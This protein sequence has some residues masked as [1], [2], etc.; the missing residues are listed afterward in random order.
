VRTRS[1]LHAVVLQPAMRTPLPS[2]RSRWMA[3]PP[4][5]RSCTSSARRDV[6]SR[7]RSE[8]GDAVVAFFE[9][10]LFSATPRRVRLE[11]AVPFRSRSVAQRPA[12]WVTRRLSWRT[13]PTRMWRRSARR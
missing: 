10:T 9:E 5:L 12:P 8:A 11:D 4:S 13:P 6:R 2:H 7:T 1:A 3:S